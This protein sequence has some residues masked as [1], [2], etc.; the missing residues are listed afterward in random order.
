MEL[1]EVDFVYAYRQ[2]GSREL[3]VF[4]SNTYGGNLKINIHI[5]T[6]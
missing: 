5:T 1:E 4:K 2:Y 3:Q 6:M